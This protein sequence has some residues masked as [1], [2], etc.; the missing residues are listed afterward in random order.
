[1]LA[2]EAVVEMDLLEQAAQAAVVMVRL[3]EVV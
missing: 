2:V 1:M 3:L